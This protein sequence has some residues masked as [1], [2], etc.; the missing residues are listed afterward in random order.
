MATQKTKTEK[1]LKEYDLQLKIYNKLINTLLYKLNNIE[2]KT[3]KKKA[4][5]KEKEEEKKKEDKEETKGYRQC[6]A[7]GLKARDNYELYL[8]KK[9]I[10][11]ENTLKINF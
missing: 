6:G 9:I 10:R 3:N 8:K 7:Y 1:Q 11:L 5:K 4:K 2:K